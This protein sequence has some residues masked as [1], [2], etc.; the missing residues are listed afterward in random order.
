MN[1]TKNAQDDLEN[2][3]YKKA[4]IDNLQI[5]IAEIE[6]SM[7]GLKSQDMTIER[8]QGGEHG[9]ALLSLIDEKT[10]LENNLKSV[11]DFINGIER[12][13]KSLTVEETTVLEAAYING[14]QSG[15]YVEAVCEQI[16]Y[17]D[18]KVDNI[19]REALRKFTMAR[20]GV[21]DR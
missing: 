4:S 5:R 1:W 16:N 19:R 12:G 20:Y 13:M 11:L 7:D 6:A 18:R 21:S 10:R 14:R 17:C 9:D 8:I 15:R 2:Y 3:K